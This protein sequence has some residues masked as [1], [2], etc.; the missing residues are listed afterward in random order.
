M[1]DSTRA[2][3]SLTNDDDRALALEGKLEDISKDDARRELEEEL[4]SR[5][6]NAAVMSKQTK[7]DLARLLMRCLYG[8]GF[9][10]LRAVLR[11]LSNIH[12][13]MIKVR[14]VSDE[15]DRSGDS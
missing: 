12:E 9:Q 4:K 11:D 3:K 5:L 6:R 14:E 8:N 1:T 13:A 10:E 7:Y 15:D 2:W